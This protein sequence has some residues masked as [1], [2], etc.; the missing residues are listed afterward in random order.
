MKVI[1]F[2]IEPKKPVEEC[3]RGWDSHD[4]MGISVLGAQETVDGVDD[5][6]RFFDEEQTSLQACLDFLSSADMLA[7]FNTMMFDIPV[8]E[9]AVRRQKDVLRFPTRR[10][11]QLPHMDV[12]DLMVR[13]EFGLGVREA[14]AQ[15]GGKI[16][17]GKKLDDVAG[18]TLGLTKSGEG[19]MAPILYRAGRYAELFDY[20]AR[21]VWIEAKLVAHVLAEKWV[22]NGRG[23]KVD[24]TEQVDAVL[25]SIPPRG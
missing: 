5:C 13:A 14:K 20:C 19:K 18:F 1:T 4:E 12:L 11:T 24:L 9:G 8:L 25:E 21:D 7:G 16:F 3:T 17:S 15:H 10:I 23:E 22:K 6:V 2:D